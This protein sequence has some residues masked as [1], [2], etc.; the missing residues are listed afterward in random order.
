MQREFN[1][2]KTLACMA[3]LLSGLQLVPAQ[4]PDGAA[5]YK[6]Q[7]LKC[8]ENPSE[9]RAPSFAAM[10]LMPPEK[11][12]RTMESGVM[13]PQGLLLTPEQRR[14]VAEYL[15]DKPLPQEGMLSAPEVRKIAEQAYVFAYPLVL[16]ELTRRTMTLDG[17]P[18]LINH[19]THIPV[20]PNDRF[21]Q[22]IRPNADTLY[23]GAWLDLAKEPI[24]LHVPDIQGR[25]Y[26]MQLM[27][28][29]S[30]T[31]S[32][33]GKRTTGTGEGWF[34]IVGPGWKG[35]L[36]AGVQRIL[37]PTSTA[38]LL[39]R[40]QT[41]GPSDYDFVHKIQGGYKLVPLSRYSTARSAESQTSEPGTPLSTLRALQSRMT[42]I[43]PPVQAERMSA[44]E[45]FI[46]FAELLKTTSSHSSD[47][48]MLGE[49]AK[50][51]IIPG[52]A[53]QP[54]RLGTERLKA[55]EDGAQAASGLLSNFEKQGPPLGKTG[56]SLPGKY[57]RYGTD[58]FARAMTAR[59]ALA[60]LPAEDA[61]YLSCFHSPDGTPLNGGQRYSLHFAKSALPPVKA[62]WSLTLYDEHGY[63]ASNAIKRFAIGDRDVLKFNPDGSLDLYV[64]HDS[65]GSEKEDNWL[66]APEGNF[67]LFLRL[68]W[69]DDAV[70]SG[71]WMP[72]AL[73]A[74]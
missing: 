35:E 41:N 74:R 73:A 58:Y 47:Q 5:L 16:M 15:S 38:W 24:L 45:F 69:P 22:V 43:P 25:Y 53:F 40:T 46:L 2:A 13:L 72:P 32:S 70:I 42:A 18:D 23:S 3:V 55:I 20:F 12:L 37:C 49:L 62:F 60:A 28:A 71:R 11:I 19:F 7:C 63:F 30:E 66:P 27:D 57:G 56:W 36:P 50:I 21:R 52:Q 64:Q 14:M 10:R 65:P 51:G 9:K 33:P 54:E 26:L 8:H 1:L 4:P 6:Q 17:S 61:V 44:V 31:I 67:N 29:W 68:Y 48:A 59:Y 34:A 39:G